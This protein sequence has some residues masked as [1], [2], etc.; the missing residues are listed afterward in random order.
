MSSRGNALGSL[1]LL[2]LLLGGVGAA[3]AWNYERNLALEEQEVRPYRTLSDTDLEALRAATEAEVKRLDARY[4][5]ASG[6]RASTQIQGV[7]TEERLRSFE[8]VQAH[9]R[10]VR[11]LGHEA[12]EL[13]ATLT[14]LQR[15]QDRRA[16]DGDDWQVFM[17]R[18]TTLP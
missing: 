3:G 5:A 15:E 8:R 13:G 6:Q 9:G 14:E 18:L 16:A 7:H 12:S 17:R 2:L 4:A 10:A 11:S 1:L